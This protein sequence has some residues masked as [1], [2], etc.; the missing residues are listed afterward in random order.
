MEWDHGRSQSFNN[1]ILTLQLIIYN[2]LYCDYT[3]TYLVFRTVFDAVYIFSIFPN[4]MFLLFLLF[5][6][7]FIISILRFCNYLP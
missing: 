6:F 3:G 7:N 5:V 4:F 2:T 1:E